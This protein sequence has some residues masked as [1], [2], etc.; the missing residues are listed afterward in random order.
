MS[1]S[2]GYSAWVGDLDCWV[3]YDDD[4]DRAA[5]SERLNIERDEIGEQQLLAGKAI[6]ALQRYEKKI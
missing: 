5:R 6:S 3:S 4:G 1:E 2:N